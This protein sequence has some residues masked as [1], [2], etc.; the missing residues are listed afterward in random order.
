MTNSRVMLTTALVALL[1]APVAA[2]R[3][4]GT[5]VETTKG[6]VQG[7]EN[8]KGVLEFKGIPYAADTGGKNRF[9]P[10][11][12]RTPWTNTLDATKF[13]AKCPQIGNGYWDDP[14][15]PRIVSEDCLFV[16]VW[17]SKLSGKRP[18]LV[19]FHG[20]AWQFG[21]G[22]FDNGTPFADRGNA[23]VVTTNS[24]LAV[25]GHLSLN[26]SF[27]PQY[28]SSGNVG[29][30]DLHMA[31]AWVKDNV[32][33]FGG[34]PN[35]VTILGASGGGA[36]TLHAMTMPAFEGMF[37]KAIIIGGHDLW[38]RNALD[39][40]RERSAAILKRLDIEPGD[41]EALQNM[42]M[43]A[44]LAAH[45]EVWQAYGPDPKAG[46]IPWTHYDLL[47]PV[48]DGKTLP[49]FPMEAIAN[50]ASANIELMLGTTRV[51]HWHINDERSQPW[52]W[53]TREQLTTALD[54]YLGQA[55]NKVVSA[56]EKVMP[57]ASPSSLLLRIT[58]DRYWHRPH[59]QL[60]EAR[61]A[62]GS[63]PTYLWL[64]DEDHIS[65]KFLAGYGEAAFAD[66]AAGQ[67]TK[68]WLSFAESGDPNHS[69]ILTWQPFT[70][71]QPSMMIFG[72]ES[73]STAP[74]KTLSIWNQRFD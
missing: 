15:A 41:T 54:P 45:Q 27:G 12:A 66:A 6:L 50:G 18:V 7:I 4:T 3:N 11:R 61:A 13:G 72:P 57:G 21:S 71:D 34:D 52:G 33:R 2:A 62:S 36:K 25:F 59:L 28:E 29:M 24:R 26:E 14:T 40:A 17:T 8:E 48:I 58:R 37:Q 53:L 23:V 1:V 10:P 73:H 46:P 39:S 31:L 22:E 42:P 49:K 56:Y 38:K 32:S 60:A 47:L 20:G 44:L 70:S 35:N 51:E 64:V 9:L 69:G 68:A 63:K 67:F 43:E 74:L 5:I 30:L 19:F 65:P 55:T 16:N